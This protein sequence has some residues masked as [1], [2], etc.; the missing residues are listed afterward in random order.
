MKQGEQAW[1]QA[2]AQGNHEYANIR[3]MVPKN[4]PEGAEPEYIV[5][6][7]ANRLGGVQLLHVDVRTD[8]AWLT[9]TQGYRT[10]IPSDWFQ[11]TWRY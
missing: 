9:W 8:G 1:L 10:R 7:G 6:E 5:K 2:G 11:S 3:Y 4:R